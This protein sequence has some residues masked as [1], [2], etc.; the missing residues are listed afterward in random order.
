MLFCGNNSITPDITLRVSLLITE[1]LPTFVTKLICRFNSFI[2]T[3]LTC[4]IKPK[5]GRQ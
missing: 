5:S 1:S 3:V 2:T 4:L